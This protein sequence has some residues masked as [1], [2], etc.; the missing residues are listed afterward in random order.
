MYYYIKYFGCDMNRSDA[1]KVSSILEAENYQRIDKIEKADIIIMLSCSVRQSPMDRIYGVFHKKTLKKGVLKILTG[2]V[3]KS[4]VEKL[5]DRFDIV[6]DI[7]K[8]K[9]LPKLIKKNQNYYNY[10]SGNNEYLEVSS[11]RESSYEAFIPIS[12][13]CNQFCSYCAVP[14]TRG[15]EINRSAKNIIKE[16]QGL[17]ESVKKITLLGQVVNLYVNPDKNNIK[18]GIKDFVSQQVRDF[19]DL[20]K[21]IAI[22]KPNV[23]ITF[24]SPYPTKFNKKLINVI[25]KYE[26]IS[27]HIH[28]PLQSGSDKI[29]RLMNRKYNSSEFLE[30]VQE[31]YEKIPEANI[32]S[33]VIVGFPN[34]SKKDFEDTLNILKKA[35]ITIVY[36]GLYSPRPGTVS[37]K[38]YKDDVLK[39]EKRKRDE[40]MTSLVAKTLSTRN[41]KLIG[42]ELKVLIQSSGEKGFFIGKTRD[43]E[44]VKVSGVNQK[45]IGKFIKVKI[46]KTFKWYLEAKKIKNKLIVVLGPTACGKTKIGVNLAKKFNGEIISADSRQVYKGMDIGTGKDLKDYGKIPYHLIDIA[47]PKDQ[48]T[49]KDWQEL[50][51]NKIEELNELNKIPLLVGGTGLYINSIIDGYILEGDSFN[52]ELRDKLN[53]LSLKQLQNKL[54]KLDL[55]AYQK[56]D[57]NNPRRLIRAIEMIKSGKSIIESRAKK[58]DLDILTLGIKF[59]RDIIYRRIDDRLKHRIEEEGMIAEIKALRKKGVSWQRLDDFGL[60]YRWQAK[61]LKKEISYDELIKYLSQAIHNFAKRQ[62]TWFNKRKDIVW[63]KNSK[64]AEKLTESFLK[65]N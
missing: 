21:Q 46:I 52:Q 35:K 33:D 42:K 43:Y 58:P 49:L 51:F 27:K 1:E 17:D 5:Q 44:I 59:D 36:S 31:I 61:Y 19:A 53:K 11:K 16:I 22:L 34:E 57:I 38:L 41:K 39:P 65:D 7:T 45:D 9:E 28:M 40:K 10:C 20:L 29:L 60:E 25:A 26:N 48:V 8:I 15:R 2:C 14:Y 50:A 18:N 55:K 37:E 62:L 30:I 63:I 47:D 54:K 23:W 12:S 3:L 56:I 4:D 64:E 6:I 32:T 24:L 13:G